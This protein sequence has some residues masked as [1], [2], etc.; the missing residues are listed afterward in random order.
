MGKTMN[1]KKILAAFAAAA[2]ISSGVT[3]TA[4]AY[5]GPDSYAD[6]YAD[7]DDE[8]SERETDL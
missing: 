2:I 4:L 6:S 3:P 5:A 8:R 7:A 1:A